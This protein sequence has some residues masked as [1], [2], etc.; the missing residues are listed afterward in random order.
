MSDFLLLCPA[1]RPGFELLARPRP[2]ALFPILGRPLLDLALAELASQ[3]HRGGLLAVSDRPAEIAAF[4][5]EGKP[6][7]LRVTLEVGERE[8]GP[9]EAHQRYPAAQVV[10]LDRLPGADSSELWTSPAALFAALAAE[11]PRAGAERLGMT[12]PQPGVFV[13]RRARVSPQAHLLGPCWIGD[14]AGLG[15]DTEI[16]PGAIIEDHC[17]IDAHATVTQ[18]FVGP[19]TYVGQMTEVRESF[20][21]GHGLLKWSN[22]SQTEVT[23]RF[24]LAALGA[25]APA[26][27]GFLGR[28]KSAW[29]TIFSSTRDRA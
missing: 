12:Q 1:G 9:A 7:G 16:G 13:H 2:L 3:G 22:G 14:G 11:L 20:A 26:D 19:E 18:S 28:V 10:P 24:L 27:G 29:K 21:W 25:R 4:L 23:D 6:W 5:L 15:P 17:L 8:L